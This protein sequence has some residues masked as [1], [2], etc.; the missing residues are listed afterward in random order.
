MHSNDIYGCPRNQKK[1]YSLKEIKRKR[2]V[3][4]SLKVETSFYVREIRDT[5]AF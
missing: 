2:E 1:N 5:D 3:N 4:I